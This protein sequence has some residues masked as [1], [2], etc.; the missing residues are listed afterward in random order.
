MIDWNFVAKQEGQRLVG[1]VPDPRESKSGVTIGCGVD[2]GHMTDKEFNGLPTTLQD[3]IEP[4]R[5]L[6]GL[7]AVRLSRH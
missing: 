6:V 5:H 3:K 2:V 7:Q 4:Y 1:Y